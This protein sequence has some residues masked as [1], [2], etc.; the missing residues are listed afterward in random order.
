MQAG[1]LAVND[2]KTGDEH[3]HYGDEPVGPGASRENPA[4]VFP[5]SAPEPADGAQQDRRQHPTQ[6][7]A[8]GAQAGA[9]P[10]GTRGIPGTGNPSDTDHDPRV[11]F[12]N[13]M[14][15]QELMVK[16]SHSLT[17]T[18]NAIKDE[19]P[20]GVGGVGRALMTKFEGWRD[21]VDGMRKGQPVDAPEGQG[22]VE[23][24]SESGLYTD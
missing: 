19:T 9:V 22:R 1:S 14:L 18:I 13:P 4:G 2:Q 3:L 20:S 24:S 17:E 12:S 11:V 6:G 10:A 15:F 16:L 5:Q 21:E 7:G 8:Q 23:M